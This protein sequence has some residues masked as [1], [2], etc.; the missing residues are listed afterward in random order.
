MTADN[1]NIGVRVRTVI[2]EKGI[3]QAELGRK[4]G[5]SPIYITRLLKRK[6]ID[7]T[8][9]NSLC[10]ATG[11]NFFMDFS[12]GNEN[13]EKFNL[14]H[15]HV[16][17]LIS[18]KLKEDKVMQ[19]EL[20]DYLGV[21]H[22]EVSRLLKNNSIDT[23]KLVL[24]SNFSN[25]FKYNFFSDFYRYT[26]SDR[27]KIICPF[28]EFLTASVIETGFSNDYIRSVIRDYLNEVETK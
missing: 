28:I 18:A 16:G 3:S 11:Y 14:T 10:M 6:T 27:E 4:L 5:K 25:F 1:V 20:G 8:T 9:L 24:I 17:N 26:T 13:R 22:Q 19:V 2:A 23:G 12:L 21:S 15:P 7:T